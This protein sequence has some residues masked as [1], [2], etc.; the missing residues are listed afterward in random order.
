MVF[1]ALGLVVPTAIVGLTP[2]SSRSAWM[3]VLLIVVVS[4]AR[5]AW[6]VSGASRRLFEMVICLFV[7][8]FLGIAPLVQLRTGVT[9]E[10]TPG[11]A[12]SFAS[13]SILVVLVGFTGIMLGSSLRSVHRPE[14]EG[15][16][17]QFSAPTLS[18]VRVYL[19]T[20]LAFSL[21]V[22]YL[23]RMGLRSI[24]SPR[25][26]LD[27]VRA[28]AWADPTTAALVGGFTTM[29]LLVACIA[30]IL[31]W[32]QRR[33]DGQVPNVPL[34]VVTLIAL[35]AVV[36]P[37]NSARYAVGTVYLALL[38][39]CAI[40]A[41][42]RRYRA[43]ATGALAAL[44]LVFPL[45]ST[46]RNTLEA[47]V[48]F[49]NPLQSLT[50]GDFDSF[51][52]I[53]NAVFYVAVHGTTHGQ[54]LLGVI[55]FW[56]PRSIWPNKAVDTGILLAEFRNYSF[57]NLSAP[58]WAEFFVNGGWIALVLGM[59]AVGY[60]A[61]A[62]DGRLDQQISL[63]GAPG[64]VGCVL[65]FYSLILLRGSL[66]QAVASVAVVLLLA[67]FLS[68]G[69]ARRRRPVKRSPVLRRSTQ[70]R[71]STGTSRRTR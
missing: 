55:F 60:F 34:A 12:S 68:T 4:A 24:V 28:V 47:K 64:I 39:A 11:F 23:Q 45:A 8:G 22:Y 33:T 25:A 5:F 35:L 65:P 15:A 66:L 62:W 41:S 48:Q 2:T 70:Q 27:A 17:L 59:V 42:I 37:I 36:N 30:Q 56:I 71:E 63:V 19:V 6:T 1:I 16:E 7:Y 18:P 49:R 46:F 54:Q 3:G 53:N 14:R 44:F 57:T 50:G 32:R 38:A 40:Y 69:F 52:Q 9:P 61:R 20:L 26:E 43:V 10:T 13:E 58:L 51:D 67:A 29:S 21:T 31:L